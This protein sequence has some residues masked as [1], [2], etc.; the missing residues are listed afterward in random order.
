LIPL[1]S[2]LSQKELFLTS[3]VVKGEWLK[4]SPPPPVVAVR[5][6]IHIRE[7]ASIESGIA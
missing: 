7:G 1:Q 3:P 5:E 6:N 2:L 4:K